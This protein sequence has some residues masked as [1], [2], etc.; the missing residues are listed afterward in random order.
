MRIGKYRMMQNRSHLRWR[1]VLVLDAA[2]VFLRYEEV[3]TKKEVVPFLG[4]KDDGFLDRYWPIWAHRRGFS[5][6]WF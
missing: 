1:R 5:G 4:D 3:S 6:S 2:G